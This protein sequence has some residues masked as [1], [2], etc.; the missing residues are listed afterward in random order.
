MACLNALAEDNQEGKDQELDDDEAFKRVVE[1][2]GIGDVDVLI[3]RLAEKEHVH[4]GLF[5]RINEIE[6]EAAK[7]DA[8]IAAVTQELARVRR[9]DLKS[10]SQRQ[11]SREEQ[12]RRREAELRDM[13]ARTEAHVL[14]WTHVCAEIEV[15]HDALGLAVHDDLLDSNGITENNVMRERHAALC[16]TPEQ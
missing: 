10:D 4:F 6:V 13:A 9:R 1:L 3:E 15:V 11:Q 8:R 14:C 5:H 7:N 16:K 12:R 2:T